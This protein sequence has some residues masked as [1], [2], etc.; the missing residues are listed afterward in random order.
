M[1]AHRQRAALER[2]APRHGGEDGAASAMWE[3]PGEVVL[4]EESTKEDGLEE[5]EEGEKF[6]F[7]ST[8]IGASD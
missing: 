2:P 7:H 8:G 6:S 3:G 4:A 1:S 5:R